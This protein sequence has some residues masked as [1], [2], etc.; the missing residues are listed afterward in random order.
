VGEWG[1]VVE[2][3]CCLEET[4]ELILPDTEGSPENPMSRECYVSEFRRHATEVWSHLVP[5][6]LGTVEK[7]VLYRQGHCSEVTFTGE[8]ILAAP[9]RDCR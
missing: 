8:V 1:S 7:P 5:H 3:G 2:V 9:E 4:L 6:S